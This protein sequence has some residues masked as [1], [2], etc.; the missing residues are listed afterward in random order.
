MNEVLPYAIAGIAV[1]IAAAGYHGVT[2][3]HWHLRY[4]WRY[5][6]PGTVIPRT[7]HDTRWHAM[8][9]AA[10]WTHDAGMIIVA[11]FLGTGWRLEPKVTTYAVAAV[12]VIAVT[13]LGARAVSR[14]FGERRRHPEHEYLED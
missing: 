11:G 10:R 2:E 7:R 9:H 5:A 12:I 3:H 1:L 8:S 13:W 6:R 14:T 4:F